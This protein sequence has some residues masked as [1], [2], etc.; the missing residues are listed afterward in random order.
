M[1][2]NLTDEIKRLSET[3]ASDP[4]SI[5][6]A[7]LAQL[8]LRQGMVDEA[9]KMSQNGLKKHPNYLK[10]HR[11]LAEAYFKNG[12][13]HSA[14]GEY[15]RILELNPEDEE[16]KSKLDSAFWEK[17]DTEAPEPSEG[18]GIED[19]AVAASFI[20]GKIEEPL[21]TPAE[22]EIV[23]QVTAPLAQADQ[24][25]DSLASFEGDM[26][27]TTPTVEEKEPEMKLEI[28][29]VEAMEPAAG[30][31]GAEEVD[32][33]FGEEKVDF[34][35][36]EA[37]PEEVIGVSEKTDEE[38][39]PAPA[40]QKLDLSLDDEEEETPLGAPL[41]DEEI[42]QA[43]T[44]GLML[45][46]HAPRRET[47]EEK[48]AVAS[49]LDALIRSFES[50]RKEHGA[51]APPGPTP[52]EDAVSSLSGLDRALNN[53]LQKPGVKAALLIDPSGL[54]VESAS[55]LQ[56]DVEESAALISNVFSS[57]QKTMET[58]NLGKV[59]RVAVERGGTRVYITR[60]GE[61]MLMVETDSTM[62]LGLLMVMAKRTS[63]TIE[64]LMS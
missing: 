54:V 22:V 37:E 11:V 24:D 64:E 30:E 25:R 63:R 32:L 43:L 29:A 48:A 62:R 12:M 13:V 51:P 27:D 20:E 8:Y 52:S 3:L 44:A 17:R 31:E 36:E 9:I 56:I 7:S 59:D 60:A 39:R 16:A 41:E 61:Y 18:L 19:R 49:G 26:E 1:A 50:I 28:P 42:E 5:V 14:K 33:L 57:S 15:E 23:E 10:G 34:P 38:F 46:K 47:P 53:L 4:D 58:L 55:N 6:F 35:F 21:A 2:E 40:E 45:E